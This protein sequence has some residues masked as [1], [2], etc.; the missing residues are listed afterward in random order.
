MGLKMAA[1]STRKRSKNYQFRLRTP[2]D[3]WRE[4]ERLGQIGHI[5]ARE[6]TQSLK[7]TNK[8]QAKI[9]HTAL[10]AVWDARWQLW[11]DALRDGPVELS[12]KQIFAIVAEV[13]RDVRSAAEDNPGSRERWLTLAED[14]RTIKVSEAGRAKLLA[15][16]KAHVG[17]RYRLVSL[18]YQSQQKL[19]DHFIAEL[20]EAA[21]ELASLAGGDYSESERLRVRPKADGLF[22]SKAVKFLTFE[23]LLEGWKLEAAPKESSVRAYRN[24]VVALTVFLGS[25]DATKLTRKDL[26]AWRDK[27]L[28][29]KA[30]SRETIRDRIAAVKSL[31]QYA[32]DNEHLPA[33][34][35]AG[36]TVKKGRGESNEKPVREFTVEEAMLILSK[37]R[38]KTGLLRWAP[39]LMAYSAA[40]I[41]EV[42]QLRKQDIVSD[43]EGNWQMRLEPEAGTVKSNK[44]RGIPIHSAV[45]AEGFVDYVVG[46]KNERIFSELYTSD[47]LR[48]DSTKLASKASQRVAKWL[49]EELGIT[50]KK[51]RPSHSWRHL[52]NTMSRSNEMDL[53]VRKS[54]VGHMDNITAAGYGSIEMTA[55]RKQIEKIPALKVD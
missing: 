1:P 49:R 8:V 31:L 25:E 53:E 39:W 29:D 14:A 4:R 5:V 28:A 47:S 16:L 40:R 10:K 44:K 15:R 30:L 52:F 3:I 46:L 19:L 51:L 6:I 55:K 54:M 34:V 24:R 11:R 33:N 13:G 17:K 50:D 42:A 35:A 48:K 18:S 9:E 20:S 37:S 12:Q 22:N 21:S 27:M 23:K 41:G 36:L 32:V 38:E 7:T 26:I 43:K 2:M 45:I